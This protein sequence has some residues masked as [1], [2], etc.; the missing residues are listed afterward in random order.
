MRARRRP[1]FLGIKP[2]IATTVVGAMLLVSPSASGAPAHVPTNTSPGPTWLW[3]VDPPR[4]ILQPFRAPATRYSAG[5]RGVDL[6]A[7]PGRAVYAPADGVVRFAGTVVDRPV[8]TIDHAPGSLGAAS[9]LSSM[10]PVVAIVPVG[11]VVRAGERIG[12]VGHGGHCDTSCVHLGVRL[13]GD[14]V[15]PLLY[16]GGV[17]RAVL[18]PVG[19]SPTR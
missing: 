2:A 13:D 14:Y 9:L 15:S 16:L 8:I 10:E 6:A 3:P 17:Q 4:T 11:A 12:T 7:A 18:L 1:G 19:P 5:H